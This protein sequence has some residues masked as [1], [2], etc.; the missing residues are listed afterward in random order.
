MDATCSAVGEAT[1]PTSSHEYLTSATAS[2]F[3]AAR[4]SARLASF[5]AKS[6]P[7]N[8][9]FHL[10]NKRGFYD[11]AHHIMGPVYNNVNPS[12]TLD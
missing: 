7:A 1:T 6:T 12:V 8:E 3:G 5:A 9:K 4:S 2:L 11:E 10:F